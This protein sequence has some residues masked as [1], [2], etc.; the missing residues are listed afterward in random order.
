RPPVPGESSTGRPPVPEDSPT[1]RLPAA[2][3]LRPGRP[4]I[5]RESRTGRMPAAG[6]LR[7]G[8][9]PRQAGEPSGHA[10]HTPHTPHAP[11]DAPCGEH[12]LLLL[13]AEDPA[14]RIMAALGAVTARVS[15]IWTSGP[16]GERRAR[17]RWQH[18]CR[19]QWH[20]ASTGPDIRAAARRIHAAEPV[21]AMLTFSLLLKQS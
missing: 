19:G 2:G 13:G 18:H 16:D 11:H 12:V 1:G 8:R 5:P 14:D 21:R 15:V 17:T 4:P 9:P 3:D 10:P 20:T 7:P 6:D